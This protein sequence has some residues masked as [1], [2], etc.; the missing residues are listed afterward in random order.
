MSSVLDP[1]RSAVADAE[2]PSPSATRLSLR[3]D[4]AVPVVTLPL[5]S[6][7]EAI[8]D[9]IRELAPGWR[10]TIGDRDV[11]LDLA[12]RDIQLL[13][14]RRIVAAL[15]DELGVDITG[16][17]LRPAALVRYAERELKLK[18]FLTSDPGDVPRPDPRVLAAP[19]PVETVEAQA[20]EPIAE[21]V[22]PRPS[23]AAAEIAS[24]LAEA[25]AESD[26]SVRRTHVV[27][28]TMRSGAAVR[29]DGDVVAFG[30]VNPGAEIVATGNILVLGALKGVA[31]A[32]AAGDDGAFIL[33]FDLRPTQLRIGRHIA[34]LPDRPAGERPPVEV[35]QLVE[36]RVVIEPYR[37][38][39][40]LPR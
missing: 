10:P 3:F 14:L 26:P 20:P 39:L 17:Y 35:A 32:G 11:R 30:D 6:A 13:D 34:I 7:F 9:Q 23:M 36:G 29:F 15:R 5:T 2:G 31:H 12:G 40:P 1:A 8:R 27:T 24:R 25:A 18:L 28:R 16:L 33:G 37:G 22:D 38:R 19:E 4:G 21:P